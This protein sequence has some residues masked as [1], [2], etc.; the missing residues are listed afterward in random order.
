[1]SD[2]LIRDIDPTLKSALR[3]RAARHG[4]SQQK[5]ARAILESVLR[6]EHDSWVSRLRNAGRSVEGIELEVPTRHAARDVN[7]G[8]WL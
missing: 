8:D 4:L 1:M 3:D 6:T 5:E 2:L 7:R